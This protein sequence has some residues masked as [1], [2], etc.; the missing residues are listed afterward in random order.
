MGDCLCHE[1]HKAEVPKA[2]GYV[3]VVMDGP[4]CAGVYNSYKV[5][6]SVKCD[7]PRNIHVARIVT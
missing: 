3:F 1:R 6:H 4:T 7:H 2:T 5:A